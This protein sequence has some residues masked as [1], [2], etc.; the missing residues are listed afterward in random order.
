MADRNQ[1]LDDIFADIPELPMAPSPEKISPDEGG[2]DLDA[3]FADISDSL[4]TGGDLEPEPFKEGEEEE[5]VD[6]GFLGGQLRGGAGAIE[7][8]KNFVVGA[9]EGVYNNAPGA[10]KGVAELAFGVP[11]LETQQAISG[12]VDA[13]K[14]IGG[15]IANNPLPAAKGAANVVGN[16]ALTSA[17]G[18]AGSVLGPAGTAAG[19]YMGNVVWRAL[20]DAVGA[21]DNFGFD[22]GINQLFEES[23]KELGFDALFAGLAKGTKAVTTPLNEGGKVRRDIFHWTHQKE[24]TSKVRRTKVENLKRMFGQ[25]AGQVQADALD[26]ATKTIGDD[27]VQETLART[28]KNLPPS[29]SLTD[30]IVSVVKGDLASPGKTMKRTGGLISKYKDEIKKAIRKSSTVTKYNDVRGLTQK[31]FNVSGASGDIAKDAATSINNVRKPFL[32]RLARKADLPPTAVEDFFSDVKMTK[33]MGEKLRTLPS[34]ETPGLSKQLRNSLVRRRKNYLVSKRAASARA[35]EFLTKI[36][37]QSLDSE[38]FFEAVR[39]VTTKGKLSGEF[40]KNTDVLFYKFRESAKDH[41]KKGMSAEDIGAY[42]L[43]NR[44]YFSAVNIGGWMEGVRMSDLKSASEEKLAL[45]S[46]IGKNRLSNVASFS[47]GKAADTTA[48]FRAAMEATGK[49]STFASAAARLT[50]GLPLVKDVAEIFS[51]NR[52]VALK[53]AH[54]EITRVLPTLPQEAQEEAISYADSIFAAIQAGELAAEAPIEDQKKLAKSLWVN[55]KTRPFVSGEADENPHTQGLAVVGGEF[56]APEDEAKYRANIWNDDN[57]NNTEKAKYINH[58][59]KKQKVM[60]YVAKE[61]SYSP[62]EEQE[63]EKITRQ[64]QAM[65]DLKNIKN[66]KQLVNKQTQAERL[67]RTTHQDFYSPEDPLLRAIVKVE[68][69]GDNPDFQVSPAG[70]KGAFQLMDKTGKVIH[71]R[72]GIE[73]EY[74]PFNDIQSEK[75]ASELLRE[76]MDRFGDKKLAL[77]AYNL[78]SPGLKK[79]IRKAG[80]ENWEAVKKFVPKETR[81]YVG[82][83]L[84]AEQEFFKA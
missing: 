79:A 5:Y 16:V 37:G 76:E 83:V 27:I 29:A 12:G 80:S 55:P 41:I 51:F 60:P 20:A 22:K 4:S 47:P 44:R 2:D 71:E 74:D 43:A 31:L 73:G 1:S 78:G 67:K 84:R 9:A 3:L 66:S 42:D 7:D 21:D 49:A 45:L 46:L 77:A 82:K 26:I 62:E 6:I 56:L 11:S 8:A 81:D 13:I 61:V 15:S 65:E 58:L 23:T 14:E 68:S 33:S 57:L 24:Q 18:L 64:E 36:E 52:I 39:E 17:G 10:I 32:V 69:G 75:I 28:G 25:H 34:I 30:Q 53:A 70:A 38:D 72:L 48:L 54:E 19:A 63:L 40:A 50:E 59:N 35:K